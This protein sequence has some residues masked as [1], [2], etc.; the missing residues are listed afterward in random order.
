MKTREEW[1][2]HLSDLMNASLDPMVYSVH[3]ARDPRCI[4]AG[5]SHR[6]VGLSA[7]SGA[8]CRLWS[9]TEIRGWY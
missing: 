8:V 2:R 5:K 7:S 9:S 6:R 1:R 3:W 4:Q